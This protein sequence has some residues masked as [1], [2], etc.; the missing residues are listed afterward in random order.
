MTRLR[1]RPSD[2]VISFDTGRVEWRREGNRPRQ[3]TRTAS[4]GQRFEPRP[5][6][7]N[8]ERTSQFSGAKV[9]ASTGRG[10]YFIF[11]QKSVCGAVGF[12]TQYFPSRRTR[13][14]RARRAADAAGESPTVGNMSDR[15]GSRPT[16]LRAIPEVSPRTVSASTPQKSVE[17][18]TRN[19]L[20]K[21][22]CRFELR[23]ISVRS[24]YCLYRDC[25]RACNVSARPGMQHQNPAK[26]APD[27][28]AS[29]A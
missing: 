1:S 26:G 17:N 27:C 2:I 29:P 11:L 7:R 21:P 4:A 25:Q 22:C 6:T 15:I 8:Q 10:G 16:T 13:P 9:R 28:Q 5:A 23:P 19:L 12:A 18:C 14:N 3:L 24:R 20:T